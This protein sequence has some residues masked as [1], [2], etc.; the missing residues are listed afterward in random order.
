MMLNIQIY[1]WLTSSLLF[2]LKDGVTNF[3]VNIANN[4][5]FKSFKYK[6]KLLGKNEAE[7]V[8]GI[9]RNTTIA[10]PLKFLS[11]FWGSLEMP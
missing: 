8:N 4:N 2:F 6:A 3:N 5:E 10:V 9:L 11:N 1:L 7:G